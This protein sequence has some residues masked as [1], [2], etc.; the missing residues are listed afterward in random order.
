[1]GYFNGKV[2]NERDVGPMHT[3]YLGPHGRGTRNDNGERLLEICAS[4]HLGISNTF[5]QHQ[6]SHAY[7]W[8]KWGDQRIRSQI[9]YI[10]TRR[11]AIRNIRVIP[12]ENVSTDHRMVVATN[13]KE[14]RRNRIGRT[15]QR[16][17]VN[18]KKLMKPDI[19]KKYQEEISY[20]LAQLPN[21]L[22]SAEKEWMD[23]KDIIQ[24]TAEKMVGQKKHGGQQK[25]EMHAN[26]LSNRP[27]KRHGQSMVAN[28]KIC[29]KQRR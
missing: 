15:F 18:I 4:H 27:K 22:N 11:K 25:N 29:E 23:F 20:K 5:F 2:G 28:W 6:D 26:T 8:Y 17:S 7:T 13:R 10:I 12:S 21:K 14:T 24:G 9:D 3:D 16:R 1:M 19:N